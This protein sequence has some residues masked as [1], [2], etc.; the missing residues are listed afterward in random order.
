MDVYNTSAEAAPKDRVIMVIDASEG[1]TAT[2]EFGLWSD[3]CLILP[4]DKRAGGWCIADHWTLRESILFDDTAGIACA[5]ITDPT[6]WSELPLIPLA[7]I[8]ADVA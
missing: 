4:D 1:E 2:W 3:D 7:N 6:H 8:V 5:I